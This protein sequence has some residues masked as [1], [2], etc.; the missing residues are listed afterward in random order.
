MI[1]LKFATYLMLLI[2]KILGLFGFKLVRPHKE[3]P[4]STD[5]EL[6]KIY[7]ACRKYTMTS[8]ER[9]YALYQAVIYLEKNKIQGDFVE[10]GVWKGGSMMVVAKTLQLMGNN[11]RR[12][13]LYDTYKGMSKPGREDKR[14]TKA[15]NLLEKWRKNKMNGYNKWTYSPLSEVKDNMSSTGYP[16]KN[17]IYVKGKVENTIPQTYVS[18]KIALLRLDTDWYSSTLHELINLYPRLS[19]GGILI[20]DD[21]GEFSG[22]QK[23]VDKYFKEAGEHVL[24]NRIDR[25]G[26]LIIKRQ[27]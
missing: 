17:I 10:C 14:L 16:A 3:I 7:N 11:K 24:L 2:Q 26:R 8:L 19:R 12:L 4:L 27:I 20:V 9:V 13:V 23:A 25:A 21:Y 22:A 15:D 18:K 1:V 6:A 5:K